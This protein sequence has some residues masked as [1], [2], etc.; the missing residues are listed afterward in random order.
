M[1]V[2]IE[3]LP[4]KHG[5]QGLEQNVEAP[6][7]TSYECKIDLGL[8]ERPDP[9]SDICQRPVLPGGTLVLIVR[10]I[11]LPITSSILGSLESLKLLLVM[12]P[13]AATPHEV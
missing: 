2:A 9:H 7:S 10:R 4:S 11:N 12:L 3:S 8:S 13:V 5:R 6:R 1:E